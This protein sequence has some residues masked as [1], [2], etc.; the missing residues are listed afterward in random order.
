M[1][2]NS[3]KYINHERNWNLEKTYFGK[4]TLLVGLSG[5][6]K[7]QIL[8]SIF[9]LKDIVEGNTAGLS[10]VE[11]DLDFVV[12]NK[13]YRWY[14]EFEVLGNDDFVKA[15]YKNFEDED[16]NKLPRILK[17]GLYLDGTL[18]FERKS[19]DIA[20]E[21]QVLPKISPFKSGISIFTEE[22]KIE[23]II[24]AFNKIYFI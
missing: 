6:G 10:G 21:G 20:Y 23:P 16:N 17:E 14:G 1:K 19:S 24:K 8:E 11:W 7:T 15:K 2:I 3:I 9:N 13:S 18:V 12:D 4:V 5:V 22:N